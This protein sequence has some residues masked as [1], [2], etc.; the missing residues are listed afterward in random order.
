MTI[1]WTEDLAVGK[2]AIDR[3]H[4]ELFYRINKLMRACEEGDCVRDIRKI[5]DFL[6]SY[7]QVHFA[8]E[9]KLMKLHH[10]P[11]SDAH[12]GEHVEFKRQL[13][14]F[15]TRLNRGVDAELGASVRDMLAGWL[16]RHIC[17]K[18]QAFG[19][20]LREAPES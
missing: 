19:R 6:E 15:A 7:A 4:E 10:F 9:E 20:F 8:E 13:Q 16:Q 12:T 3:Q 5:L 18:D 2:T 1:E 14:Q 11:D 17:E